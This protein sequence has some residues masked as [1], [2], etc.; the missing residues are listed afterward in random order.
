MTRAIIKTLG[1]AL[2]ATLPVLANAHCDV[3]V[4]QSLRSNAGLYYADAAE[5]AAAAERLRTDEPLAQAMGRNGQDY[6]ARN[7]AWPIVE[8]KY[9]AMLDRLTR[10]PSKHRME[11]L[12]GFFA[13]RTRN[14]PPAAEVLQG[15]PKGTLGES[16]KWKVGSGK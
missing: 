13:R 9:L 6:Y 12:P 3:L 16:G 4:G 15:L 8:G 2:V 5:F 7:Y 10:E 14:L 11:P 1:V